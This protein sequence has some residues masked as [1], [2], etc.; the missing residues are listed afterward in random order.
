MFTFKNRK[1]AKQANEE[2]I[3]YNLH[4]KPSILTLHIFLIRYFKEK[5]L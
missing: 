4:S 3:L 2:D 5:N 1:S